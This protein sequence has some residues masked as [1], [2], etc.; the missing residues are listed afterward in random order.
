MRIEVQPG[1]RFGIL[2]AL[3]EAAPIKVGGQ[4]YRRVDCLCDC[5]NR[6]VKDLRALWNHKVSSCGCRWHTTHGQTHT[7]LYGIWANMK[8]RCLNPAN[9]AWA[10]YGG[11]GIKLFPGWTDFEAFRGWARTHGYQADLTIDRIDNDRGYEP[12]NCRWV[13]I[14]KQAV[15]RS[16]NHLL[17]ARGQTMTLAEWARA[18]GMPG[19]ALRLRLKRGWP[20]DEA[21]AIPIG[22]RRQ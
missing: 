22:G 21:L 14:E 9:P 20:L 8:Q 6:V 15:N 13:P 10:Q 18:V 2:T 19:T 7:R 11:R 4:T 3:G 1:H 12:G 17:T 16:N 5:G